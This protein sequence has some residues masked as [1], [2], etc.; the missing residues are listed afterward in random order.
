M[1]TKYCFEDLS[2]PRIGG[3]RFT[4][5]PDMT[6]TVYH[7]RTHNNYGLLSKN[8]IKI[9]KRENCFWKNTSI[10]SKQASNN[11]DK[12]YLLYY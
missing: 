3:V 10:V 8:A 1:F 9:G 6:I 11:L 12:R 2:L 7:G 4:D 5:L